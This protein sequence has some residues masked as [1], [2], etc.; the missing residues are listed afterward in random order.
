MLQKFPSLDAVEAAMP[1]L[2]EVII[3][4]AQGEAEAER[5]LGALVACPTESTTQH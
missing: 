4:A 3:R 5:R 2:I 1:G